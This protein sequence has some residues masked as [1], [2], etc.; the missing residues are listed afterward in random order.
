MDCGLQPGA[1]LVVV[2][3]AVMILPTSSSTPA[4]AGCCLVGCSV[5]N[6][7]TLCSHDV[8]GVSHHVLIGLGPVLE[9]SAQSQSV[10][11]VAY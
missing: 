10:A 6:G 5:V 11:V 1:A 9:S 2:Q 4:V 7:L 3:L 8:Y